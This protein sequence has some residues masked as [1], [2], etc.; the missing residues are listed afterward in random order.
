MRQQA[1]LSKRMLVRSGAA[2]P[3]ARIL[4]GVEVH[5]HHGGAA[6][7]DAALPEEVQDARESREARRD[8]ALIVI[9]GLGWRGGSMPRSS[10]PRS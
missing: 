1:T 7:A 6:A 3:S 5:D 4:L 8:R 10:A 2:T 9:T